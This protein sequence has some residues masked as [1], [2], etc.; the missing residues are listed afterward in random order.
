[1]D[2]CCREGL[3]PRGLRINLSPTFSSDLDFSRDWANVIDT[4]ANNLLQ[5]LINKRYALRHIVAEEIS[6]IL[7]ELQ[8]YKN[9]P[10]FQTFNNRTI[11]E[12]RSYELEIINCKKGKLFRDRE[13]KVK[14]TY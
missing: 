1:M 11:S 4:C 8:S 3:T 12:S 9:H 14:G 10:D 5:L 7:S 13:D 6:E 2:K